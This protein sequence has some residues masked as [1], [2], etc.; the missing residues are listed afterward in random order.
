M[1]KLPTFLKKILFLPIAIIG[2]TACDNLKKDDQLRQQGFIYCSDNYPKFLNPQ[3][4]DGSESIKAIAPQLFDSLLILD[5]S[6]LQPKPHLATKWVSNANNTEYTF[7]LRE[8][9][10]FQSTGWFQPTRPFNAQ[11]V[12]FSFK[13]IIDSSNPYHYVNGAHYPWFQSIGLSKLVKDVVALDDQHVTF[14]LNQTDN[15]FLSNISTVF[16]AIHSAEYAQ[17]LADANKKSNIDLLPIGT[18]PFQMVSTENYDFIRLTRHSQY[19]NGD[20][21]MKQVVFDFANRGT[22][23]LAKL[24]RNECD[25]MTDPITSQLTVLNKA[26][27][28]RTNISQAMNVAFVA[29]NTQH[30]ALNDVRVRQALSFAINRKNIL[31]SVYYGKG[32]VATSL[33]PAESW[34]YQDNSEQIRYDRAY[35]K[36]LLK[37]A[38]Y[39]R[40]LQLTLWVPLAAQSFNPN[41]HKTAELLQ[42][43][44][45][46][47]GIQ[48][49]I[50]TEE[51]VKRRQLTSQPNTDLVLTGWSANTG[52]PD[53]LLRPLLSCEAQRAGLN[54][55]MW[56]KPDFDFLLTLARDGEQQRFRTNLYHQAQTMLTQALP[57]IPI[58]HGVQY[59]VHHRSLSGFALNPFNSGSFEH[60]VREK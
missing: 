19:W 18:G 56:C 6:T 11:D 48:L 60:V 9:V 16:A 46:D 45:A 2:L 5:P 3:L 54:I 14:I 41:P 36:A 29:L 17:L 55:S 57:I 27:N 49:N 4:S 8:N 32:Q 26:Q 20:V 50:V 23:T 24:L 31:D 35:A 34:A 43:D 51:N 28:I 15:T 37:Q 40:G 42:S 58:A 44:F 47:I 38:G 12:V 30:F 59:Q 10:E 25:V 53:S 1:F 52:E 13:R 33:L 21:K 39:E 22:G 7:T